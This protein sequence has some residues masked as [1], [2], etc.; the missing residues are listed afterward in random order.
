MNK[1]F[2]E[3]KEETKRG[4]QFLHI[5]D[6]MPRRSETNTV[7]RRPPMPDAALKKKEGEPKV[8]VTLCQEDRRDE[9]CAHTHEEESVAVTLTNYIDAPKSHHDAGTYTDNTYKEETFYDEEFDDA[10]L[11]IYN[12]EHVDTIA[13]LAVYNEEHVDVNTLATNNKETTADAL[14]ICDE[15]SATLANYDEENAAVE[16]EPWGA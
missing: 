14:D 10:T 15:E 5:S 1:T 13:T 7:T 9:A 16:G 11:A 12:E 2:P 4:L 8:Q 6:N 3:A